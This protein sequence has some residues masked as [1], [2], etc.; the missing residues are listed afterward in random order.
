[1]LLFNINLFSCV[2]HQGRKKPSSSAGTEQL[3]ERHC[4]CCRTFPP[5]AVP[6]KLLLLLR[7]VRQHREINGFAAVCMGGTCSVCFSTNN[8][9]E[10]LVLTVQQSFRKGS[11]CSESVA[12]MLGE[13]FASR[14]S[15]G[16]L[17]KTWASELQVV[18]PIKCIICSCKSQ[19]PNL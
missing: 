4:I 12:G 5:C 1:M 19:T 3:P 8:G 7:L 2:S 18:C 9:C 10:D 11:Q 16:A 6:H 17:L 14:A 15:L 13:P